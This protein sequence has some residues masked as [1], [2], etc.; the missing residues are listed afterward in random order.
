MN[1]TIRILAILLILVNT[2]A[3]SSC[4]EHVHE[5]DE[6]KIIK[7]ATCIEIGI[8]EYKCIECGEVKEEQIE[9]TE[10][11]KVIDQ[12]V[13]ATCTSTGLTEGSHC[14]VCNEVIKAQEKI[15]KLNHNY[16]DGICTLCNKKVSVGLNYTLNSDG[17]SYVVTGIGTCRDLEI[18]IP[19]IYNKLPVEE[20]AKGAFDDYK[21][22]KSIIIPSSIEQIGNGVFSNCIN[23]ENIEIDV[24]NKTYKSI[25]GNLYSIDD[26]ILIQYALGK[27]DTSFIIPDGVERI[28]PF[29]FTN[30]A[31]LE[32]I[33]ISNSVRSIEY[34][35]FQNCSRL[36]T[37]MISES[38]TSI[39]YDAF[40]GCNS[41]KNIIVN[42][43]N[44]AYKSIDGNLYKKDG[45]TLILYAGGKEKETFLID[46]DVEEIREY[47]FENCVNLKKI[48][49]GRNSQL[50]KINQYAFTG[51]E[52][53]IEITI[54]SGVERIGQGVF[55]NCKSLEKIIIPESVKFMDSNVFRGC[56]NLTI[57]C[58]ARYIPDTW[59]E[60]WNSTFCKVIRNYKN[61]K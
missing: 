42:E 47:A 3:L 13:N 43:N 4:G 9:R 26:E 39:E 58:E 2:F 35:A 1:K 34:Y 8:K 50:K 57:Y 20:I 37:V 5:L 40:R 56:E 59:K 18:V 60:N 12:M 30:S 25:D 61:N 19:E 15:K 28:F 22:L 6:G 29:A 31:N 52:N 36:T 55:Y 10:H 48:F 44:K 7:N 23:L 41:L 38:V 32:S 27:K 49:F 16:I 51:C 53:L 33:E 14:S 17:S 24:N 54:P 46:K 21:D 11:S 45:K